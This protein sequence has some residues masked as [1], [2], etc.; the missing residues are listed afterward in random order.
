MARLG[1]APDPSQREAT[2]ASILGIELIEHFDANGYLL[3]RQI[4]GSSEPDMPVDKELLVASQ[5]GTINAR[6]IRLD[7]GGFEYEVVSALDVIKG[8]RFGEEYL[9][10]QSIL[11]PDQRGVI[12]VVAD[13]PDLTTQARTLI[14]RSIVAG[15]L[16]ISAILIGMWVFLRHFVSRPLRRYSQLAMRIALG[17]RVRMPADRQDELGELGRAV[18][19]MAD[20][21]EHQATVDSLTGLY[22]LRHLSSHLEVLIDDASRN[23]EPLSVVFADLDNLKPVNDTYGH[24]AGD[25]V[26]RAIANTLTAWAG[27]DG[28]CWRLSTGGDE[29]VA[30]LPN[31]GPEAALIR[32]ETLRRMVSSLLVPVADSQIRPSIS[33]GIAS[34]PEDG[35][36]AALLSIADRRMYASKTMH[37]EERRLSGKAV[38]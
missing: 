17:E 33:V 10:P 14:Y 7:N 29:F 35:N 25:R 5:S 18:N 4:F 36:S 6:P 16:I 26:L 2:A 12:R 13:Y 30:A 31:T 8:G 1:D 34:Y 22:N 24:E 28:I 21:L 15:D 20:A 9:I 11:S 19:G 37:T 38:A 3:D 27:E 23:A 32:A